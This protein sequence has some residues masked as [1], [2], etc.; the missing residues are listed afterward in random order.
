MLDGKDKPIKDLLD[1]YFFQS[2]FKDLAAEGKSSDN[3][4]DS[5]SNISNSNNDNNKIFNNKNDKSHD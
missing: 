3:N 5:K 1:F 4:N 2:P